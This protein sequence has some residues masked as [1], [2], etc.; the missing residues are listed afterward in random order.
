[1]VLAAF[2]TVV[3]ARLSAKIL[4]KVKFFQEY[5]GFFQYVLIAR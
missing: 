5:E 4:K 1:M 2:G 3:L